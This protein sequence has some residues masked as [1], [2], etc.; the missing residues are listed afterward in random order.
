MVY[1][2]SA[3]MAA[4]E[5]EFHSLM[6]GEPA[7]PPQPPAA[8]RVRVQDIGTAVGMLALCV[9][10]GTAIVLKTADSNA[11][12]PA[13][14]SKAP[15]TA[16]AALLPRGQESKAATASHK[17][18]DMGS[19]ATGATR[20]GKGMDGG[21]Y[22]KGGKQSLQE[23]KSLCINGHIAPTFVMPGCQKCGTTSF[24][25]DMYTYML[26]TKTGTLAEGDKLNTT[27][28]TYYSNTK[29][30]HF[31]EHVGE[32]YPAMGGELN[33]NNYWNLYPECDGAGG[34][35]SPRNSAMHKHTEESI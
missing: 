32:E 5:E 14:G 17:S 7:T 3:D 27:G 8:P 25:D 35:V 23:R 4:D 33:N 19:G 21:A 22:D 15:A 11:V 24:Y 16:F 6:T 2:T 28:T 31:Y 10:G 1:G 20:G 30:K 12:P 13:E 26:D 9:V 18:P 34:K 29:E